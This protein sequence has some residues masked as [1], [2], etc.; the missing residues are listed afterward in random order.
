MRTPTVPK[1]IREHAD[2]VRALVAKNLSDTLKEQRWSRR[3]AATALGLTHTYVNARAAGDV[4]LSA[5]DLALFADFLSVPITRFFAPTDQGGTI[6]PLP[7]REVSPSVNDVY[8]SRTAS[9]TNIFDR[10]ERIAS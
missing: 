4:D 2:E 5:S 3:Q 7:T 10:T 6:T 1:E 8:P 9:I